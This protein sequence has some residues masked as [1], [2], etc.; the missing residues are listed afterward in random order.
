MMRCSAIYPDAL[1]HPLCFYFKLYS[2]LQDMFRTLRG[3]ATR[4]DP[5][6]DGITA[7]PIIVNAGVPPS[8]SDSASSLQAGDTGGTQSPGRPIDALVVPADDDSLM[9]DRVT[10]AAY[11]LPDPTSTRLLL[12]QLIDGL[13]SKMSVLRSS[14]PPGAF[15]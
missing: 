12:Q 1:A 15:T 6:L 8:A 5:L 4:S 3:L 14:S 2:G 11:A 7:I 13:Q 9:V 10:A